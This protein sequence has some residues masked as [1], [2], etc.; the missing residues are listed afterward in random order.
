MSR[1]HFSKNIILGNRDAVMIDIVVEF[2]ENGVLTTAEVI[3]TELRRGI[4]LFASGL[5][6]QQTEDAEVSD[7]CFNNALDIAEH[8]MKAYEFEVRQ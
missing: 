3:W 7:T 4:G 6:C 8:L 1:T 2:N 5:H